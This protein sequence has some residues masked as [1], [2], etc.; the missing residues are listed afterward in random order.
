MPLEEMERYQRITMKC[1]IQALFSAIFCL[2]ASVAFAQPPNADMIQCNGEAKIG[3]SKVS[4]VSLVFKPNSGYVESKAKFKGQEYMLLLGGDPG[5]PRFVTLTWSPKSGS[6]IENSVDEVQNT[7]KQVQ[8]G[9]P[10]KGAVTEVE[11]K[12]PTQDGVFFSIRCFGRNSETLQNEL[13]SQ[14]LNNLNESRT[15]K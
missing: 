8:I 9:V 11:S 14:L 7:I 4:V 5:G 12:Y 13:F 3:K 15:E 10:D 1:Q 6:A 2:T